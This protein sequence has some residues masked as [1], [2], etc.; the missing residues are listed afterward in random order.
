M[1]FNQIA[2][3]LVTAGVFGAIAKAL[4]QPL[5]VGYLFAGLVL[6]L[7]GFTQGIEV[8]SGLGQIGVT[9][10]LF[11][12]GLELNP[13]ELKDV[14]KP[15]TI[16]GIGQIVFTSAIG[17]LIS[18][19]LGFSPL[20]SI[21]VAV[22]L[23][24]SSTIIMV[25]LLS[26][27]KD[28]NSL[29]G[30]ISV[31]FLLIQDFVAL[32][33]LMVLS[34]LTKGT[35]APINFL[36]L[37]F[38]GGVLLTSIWLLSKKV[39]PA[40]FDK[41]LAKTPELLF[42][43]SIAW[44]LGV[45]TIVAG[46]LGFSLEIGGFLAGLALS[47]LHEHLSISSHTKPL[48]DFFLVIF[49]LALGSKLVVSDVAIVLPKALAFSAFVLVGNPLIVMVI[50]GLIGYRKRTSFLAG[51]TV[52][53]ISEFSFILM[54]MGLSLG[55]VTPE[56]LATVVLVGVITMTASTYMIL[57]AD[58]LYNLFKNHLAIFERKKSKEASLILEHKMHDHVILIGHARAGRTLLR[59][60]K[61][62]SWPT[63]VVDFDPSVF[64]RLSADKIPVLFGD[65]GDPDIFDATH[66]DNARL[67]VSTITGFVDSLAL[68]NQT[69]SLKRKIPIILTATSRQDAT[70][71]Y[72]AGATFVVVP[73][74]AAG[75]HLRQ[76]FKTYGTST[77]KITSIGKGHFKRM[78]NL[79]KG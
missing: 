67:I 79:T 12:V 28:L 37:A 29:Y 25:K 77:A 8:F 38:K 24:F 19:L 33:I 78:I 49:F 51:L 44:A 27:K 30:K 5:L 46:P 74:V 4:K 26:E 35:L 39:I 47:N 21:Y 57:E 62:R 23:T 2:L 72:E 6:S 53:Q 69:K 65:I 22:A 71:L 48:R 76:I 45:A 64:N 59:F 1:Q 34:G 3:L 75:E 7:L 56:A 13:R 50:L 54:A 70:A 43:S 36:V 16:T 68:L 20:T 63:L 60:F 73:E 17:F 61:A 18:L 52:A 40:L 66:A 31:G 11:L 58:K 15:A 14:G 32:L 55:H 9:L 10:L 41:L 42:I